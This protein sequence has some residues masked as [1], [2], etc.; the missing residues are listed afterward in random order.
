MNHTKKEIA[1]LFSTGKFLSVLAYLTDDI[2][3]NTIGDRSFKG[4]KSVTEHC[5]STAAY[6]TS[7]E[8]VFTT[9]DIL[10]ADLKVVVTG[11]AEFRKNDQL[12]H[13]ISACDIYEF[14]RTNQLKK[15]DSYCIPEKKQLTSL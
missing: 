2:V 11:T 10:I 7:V 3:W 13:F 6:F 14:D 12:L 15:I 1:T 4:K 8:T 9:N 5:E